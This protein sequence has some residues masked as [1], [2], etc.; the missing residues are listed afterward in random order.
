MPP[1]IRFFFAAMT[2][3]LFFIA[4]IPLYRELSRRRDI[5]WTPRPMALSLTESAD[6]VEIYA[7]GRPLAALLE[8][9]QVRVV[10]DT[11]TSVLAPGD[12]RLRFNNW[13]RVRAAQFPGLLIPAAACGAAVLMLVLVV[14]GRLVY[15][16]ERGSVAA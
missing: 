11:R 7:R 15:R 2:T 12:V 4:A 3:S 6:R 16:G 9:G 10:E 14:T 1:R 13:D 5:W 8:R